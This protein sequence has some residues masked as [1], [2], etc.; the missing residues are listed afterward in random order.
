M[1]NN[2]EAAEAWRQLWDRGKQRT[3]QNQNKQQKKKTNKRKNNTNTMQQQSIKGRNLDKEDVEDFGHAM[4]KKPEKH[5]AY[6]FKT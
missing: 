2:N 1:S 4:Q 3:E 5:F 6:A